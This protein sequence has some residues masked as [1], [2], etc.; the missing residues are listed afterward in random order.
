MTDHRRARHPKDGHPSP[1]GRQGTCVRSGESV[2]YESTLDH[3]SPP[4]DGGPSKPRHAHAWLVVASVVLVLVLIGLLVNWHYSGRYDVFTPGEA[5]NAEAHVTIDA[6]AAGSQGCTTLCLR[7][8]AGSIHLTTVG[9]FYGAPITQLIAA[10]L[11]HRDAIYPE[12]EYPNTPGAEEIAM[13]TSQ[14]DGE[15][16]ALGEI[17]G[18]S[19]L[20]LDGLLVVGVA[21]NTPAAKALQPG[22]VIASADGTSLATQTAA[23]LLQDDVQARGAGQSVAVSVIRSGKTLPLSVGIVK[24]PSGSS[25]PLVIGVEVEPDYL[26]PVGMKIDATGIGGPSAGLSWA[27]AIVNLLGP[28]DLTRGRTIADTGTI[29]YEGNVGDIG[30]I[31]QKVYGAENVGATIFVC[32]KDQA[33]DARA[34]AKKVGYHLRV[35]GV[36]TL[37]E[38]VQDLIGP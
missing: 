27:L 1:P 4:A 7:K 37:H 38:A 32:P 36:S 17:L 21:S 11:N 20:K 33:A 5:P 2:L 10:K 26:L 24:N 13:D 22:D 34:A 6:P 31:Q 16:A 3:P 23:S 8:R 28:N 35:I 29:D 25:P 30:G 12:T 18:Y 19:A 9:V 15:I 14:H